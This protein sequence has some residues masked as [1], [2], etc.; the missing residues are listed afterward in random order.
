MALMTRS[1]TTAPI[2]L[3][4]KKPKKNFK[5]TAMLSVLYTLVFFV[6]L[7]GLGVFFL[8]SSTEKASDFI[9]MASYVEAGL[10]A[11]AHSEKELAYLEGEK[12]KY[13][14]QAW[15]LSPFH[16]EFIG[17]YKAFAE[18]KVAQNNNILPTQ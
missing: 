10:A 7:S 8:K 9:K 5:K 4:M 1:I 17:S 6:F 14:K 15:T 11:G 16:P 2:I 18:T 13:L 3:I 12:E